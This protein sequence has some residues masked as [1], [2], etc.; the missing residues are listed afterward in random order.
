MPMSSALFASLGM[1]RKAD[2]R[3]CRYLLSWTLPQKI[4]EQC[5]NKEEKTERKVGGHMK[6][7]MKRME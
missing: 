7:A 3:S 4:V 6:N 5:E 1:A 2:L